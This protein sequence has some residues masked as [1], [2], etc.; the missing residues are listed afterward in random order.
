MFFRFGQTAE[1]AARR[2]AAMHK[3]RRAQRLAPIGQMAD[4]TST[5]GF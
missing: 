5:G 1:G 2:H 3:S 4:P